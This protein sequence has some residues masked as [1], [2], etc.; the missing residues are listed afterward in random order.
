MTFS[1]LSS[2]PQVEYWRFARLNKSDR[3]RKVKGPILWQMESF[4]EFLGML[5]LPEKMLA[6][7]VFCL[8]SYY[9]E[10]ERGILVR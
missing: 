1:Y 10:H 6:N 4:N 2:V 7:I 3:M 8:N 5:R 9:T